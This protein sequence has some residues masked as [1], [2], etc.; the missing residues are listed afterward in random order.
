MLVNCGNELWL[1]C[2]FGK[3]DFGK[4]DGS[5]KKEQLS[6]SSGCNDKTRTFHAALESHELFHYSNALLRNCSE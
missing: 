3:S 2:G 1:W 4:T 6:K 5:D